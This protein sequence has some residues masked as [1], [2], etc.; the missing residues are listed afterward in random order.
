MAAIVILGILFLLGFA[1]GK[2]LSILFGSSNK[3]H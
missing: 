1:L 3:K 2:I